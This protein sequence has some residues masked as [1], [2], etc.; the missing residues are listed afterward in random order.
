MNDS[1]W[2]DVNPVTADLPNKGRTVIML[3]VGGIVLGVLAFIGTRIRPVGL[4]AG[5]FALVTGIGIFLR[6]Q[7]DRFKMAIALTVA[8]FLMLLANPR[9]GVVAGFAV[10]FLIIGAIGLVVLGIFKAIK[11]SW[12]LGKRS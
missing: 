4:A 10:H 12:D 8:G 11:I 7:K 2:K 3:I 6:R 5:V 9:F 1:E